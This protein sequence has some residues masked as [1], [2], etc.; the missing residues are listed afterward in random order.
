MKILLVDDSK[1]MRDLISHY[2]SEINFKNVD[3]KKCVNAT[4]ALECYDEYK[5]DIVLLDYVLPDFTG[6]EVIKKLRK[7]YDFIPVIMVTSQDD[8]KLVT[9]AINAGAQNYILKDRLSAEALYLNI[10]DTIR[11][12]KGKKR[13]L[14]YKAELERSNEELEIFCHRASHDLQAPLRSVVAFSQIL[15][16]RYSDVYDEKAHLYSD[17]IIESGKNMSDL[18][19]SLLD[20]S[21]ITLIKKEA[22]EEDLNE[23]V[24]EVKNSL[25]EDIEKRNA[26]IEIGKLPI[27]KCHKFQISQLF[28]NLI[29]NA[30]KY[31][32]SERNP[33]IKIKAEDVKTHYKFSIEDNGMGISEK[34]LQKIFKPFERLHS[35]DNISGTGIGL[36]TCTKAVKIH[37]GIITAESIEGKGSQFIF[38]IAKKL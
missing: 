38:T 27:A 16:D 11:K 14:L 1:T 22:Q 23:L 12:I 33:K 21:T 28:Q 5:P 26:I 34:N 15:K 29:L 30:L 25:S 36:A 4:E 8:V 13:E 3:I 18:I 24:E 32:S 6:L 17:L 7:K 31:S 19:N 10:Q 37:R 2:L 20:F 9:E 35:Q